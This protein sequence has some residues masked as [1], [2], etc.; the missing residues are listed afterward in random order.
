MTGGTHMI[1]T[2]SSIVS[3]KKDKLIVK[4]RSLPAA[5]LSFMG[6]RELCCDLSRF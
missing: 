3:I 1:P 5:A 2:T 4:R 6:F